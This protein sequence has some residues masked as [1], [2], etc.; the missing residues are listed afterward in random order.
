MLP[1]R[2]PAPYAGPVRIRCAHFVLVALAL[3][4]SAVPAR[5][6][7]G[8]P[9]ASEDALARAAAELLL[10]AQPPASEVLDRAV[11]EAGSD[12]VGVRALFLDAANPERERAWVLQM[13]E[14]GDA[15]VV[16]GRSV[17]TPG[18]LLV[19]A[20]RAGAL[21]PLDG[22]STRVR[23]V[24]ARGF[25]DA[26]LVVS[27]ARARLQRVPVDRHALAE[28]IQIADELPRPARVQLVAH[29]AAGPRP[30]AERTIPARGLPPAEPDEIDRDPVAPGDSVELQLAALRA[31][32]GSTH[33]R[34]NRMLEAVA[35][36]HAARVCARQRVAHELGQGDPEERLR[37]AGI[38]A[39]VVGETV[40]RAGSRSAAF[41]AMRHSPSHRMTLLDRRFTNVG[42]GASTDAKGRTCLVVLLAAWPR[43][44]GR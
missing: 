27:D 43:Y 26:E 24:L 35:A 2:M 29:G 7:D 13:A 18:V 44:L 25:T 11:R 14:R 28:G 8:L 31:V 5:A 15:P 9:C 42:F 32:E 10:A 34:E 19:A 16:C 30:I 17:G 33:V 22:H 21:D 20:L 6:D 4:P 39:R 36:E 38:E 23:G 1:G 40:A 37:A 12:V 3:R 41:A